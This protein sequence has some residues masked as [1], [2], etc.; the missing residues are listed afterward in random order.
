MCKD[1]VYSISMALS[2]SSQEIMQ[3][4]CECPAG[5]GPHGSCKLIAALCYALVDF[6]RFNTTPEYQTPTDVLQK[7]N[8]PCRQDLELIPVHELGL[9][10][11]ELVPSKRLVGS[12]VVFDPRPSQTLIQQQSAAA[13]DD[14]RLE[15]LRC[16]LVALNVPC[17]LLNILVPD[18]RRIEH[19]HCYYQL[20]SPTDLEQTNNDLSL[21]TSPHF[22]TTAH[23]ACTT[24][25]VSQPEACCKTEGDIIDRLTLSTIE[26]ESLEKETRKQSSSSV[27]FEACRMRI[28]GSICGCIILQKEKTVALLYSC[29][30]PK[31][32]IH[33]PKPIA[34]GHQHEPLARNEY[35][36]VSNMN[37]HGHP[38]LKTSEA[39]FIIHEDKCWL[40]ASPDAWVVD[41]SVV[42]IYGLAEFKCPISKANMFVE[43]ACKDPQFCCTVINN[44][45]QLKK[46]HSYY[47]QIQ[48]QLFVASDR[49][50]WCD[51]VVY[52]LKNISVERI[53]PQY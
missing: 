44:K 39:G 8:Q 25:H 13:G 11:K 38:G 3:A 24:I 15:K 45:I 1:R 51:F 40:G 47:H 10:R 22:I 14:L 5:R 26:C 2:S 46:N 18:T 49:V 23:T 48:L 4:E 12:N 28:T 20:K 34:W 21:N 17:G 42:K 19:D 16:D 31:P 52:T 36:Y 43:E 9:R 6:S 29:L 37:S 53:Y 41:P 27:W 33:L 35:M 7:W 30:Y 32:M 50:H